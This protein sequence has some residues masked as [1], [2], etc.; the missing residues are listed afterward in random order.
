MTCA[1][2]VPGQ[3]Q[4]S[5][6]QPHG[7]NVPP[8]NLPAWTADRNLLNP[9]VHHCDSV[10]T[11]IMGEIAPTDRESEEKAAATI[12]RNYRGYRE[13][14]QLKGIGLDASARWA[15]VCGIAGA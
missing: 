14:R 4:G 8:S 1:A 10:Y 11:H 5:R 9:N 12:Q 15:E 13:R 7:R 3:M 2:G 6:V